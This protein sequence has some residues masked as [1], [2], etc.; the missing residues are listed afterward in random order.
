[1]HIQRA[2]ELLGLSEHEAQVYVALLRLGIATSTDIAK[3]AKIPRTTCAGVLGAL[4][5]KGLVNYFVGKKGGSKR[6]FSAE[7]PD[8]F[9]IMIKEREAAFE[10]IMPQL[11]ALHRAAGAKP[12]VYFYEGVEHTRKIF[13]D[14]IAT[15]KPFL[16]I[17]SVDDTEQAFGDYFNDLFIV[18]HES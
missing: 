9:L 8:K 5:E 13:D 17:T 12:S 3:N 7:N 4:Q 15:Q 6:M 11:K 10:A 18:F 16:A 1:M 14:I 2:I